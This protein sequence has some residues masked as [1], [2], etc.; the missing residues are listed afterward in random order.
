MLMRYSALTFNGH[1]IHYDADYCREVEGYP[2]LVIHG[3]LCATLLAGFAQEIAA[4]SIKEFRYR[5]LQP[6]FIGK[7]LRLNAVVND[8]SG[9][10]VWTS[11]PDGEVSMRADVVF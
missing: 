5:G 8:D 9:M 10:T 2:N 11:L 7:A 3:P 1:R 4:R 6:S